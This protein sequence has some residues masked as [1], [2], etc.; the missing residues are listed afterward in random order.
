MNKIAH[1]HSLFSK[2]LLKCDPS[3]LKHPSLAASFS[4]TMKG[5]KFIL[6]R[7]FV[8]APK[9]TDVKIVEEELP[10][11]KD[12]EF[13]CES[14]YI[15][16]DPY[17]RAYFQ[18]PGDVILGSQVA[19]IL[20]SKNPKF[21]TGRHVVS[22]YGWK[23]HH[24]LNDTQEGILP[25]YL[26]PDDLDAPLS[27]FLGLL[28]MPGVT[29]HFGFL[30]ICQPK[31]GETVVVTGAAG[32]VGNIVGQIAKN[33]QCTVIGVVGSEEKGKW[34]TGDLGFDGYINYKKDNISKDLKRLAPN[35]VNCYFDNVGGEISSQIMKQMNEFGRI[36]VC[37]A[38]S[39]YDELETAKASIVQGSMVFNQLKM[40]GFHV[41][42]FSNKWNDA[43]YTHA[44]WLKEGR[45][46]NRETITK[47][48]EN[49]FKAF[50]E[51]L[52]GANYGKAIV[53]I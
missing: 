17:Q 21:P 41:K 1:F 20:E 3:Y 26:I 25:K 44:Q 49:T 45:L 40:E 34:I 12:G 37:G 38:I 42:R 46:K 47:G 7:Q 23:T 18:K 22:Y 15:S 50:T 53:E 33:K 31:P 9:E 28:G 11:L 24:V 43:V 35:G 10:P 27:L 30:D 16:V 5:K 32:A 8:G 19:K 2:H 4:T 39:A 13:L 36:S 48:F 51:M 14:L 6:Q 52:K 29:A